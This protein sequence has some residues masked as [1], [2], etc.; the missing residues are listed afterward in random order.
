MARQ[1]F[2]PSELF[3]DAAWDAEQC[4]VEVFMKV[5][6]D[7]RY[8]G[9]DSDQVDRLPRYLSN[10]AENEWA[11]YERPEITVEQVMTDMQAAGYIHKKIIDWL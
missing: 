6:A 2:A 8:D 7:P 1:V 10:M 11:A 3:F 4:H 5:I 9:L